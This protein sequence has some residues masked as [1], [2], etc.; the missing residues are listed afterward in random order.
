[1]TH[2]TPVSSCKRPSP[3]D[4]PS[5]HDLSTR[6]SGPLKRQ[7]TQSHKTASLPGLR[8][9]VPSQH[10]P[11]TPPLDAHGPSDM[12]LK[13]IIPQQHTNREQQRRL[14]RR[15]ADAERWKPKLQRP[16]PKPGEITTA[17]PLKLMRHYPDANMCTLPNFVRPRIDKSARLSRLLQRFPLTGS[18]RAGEASSS[19]SSSYSPSPTNEAIPL[20]ARRDAFT[21]TQRAHACLQANKQMTASG[22]AQRLAWRSFALSETGRVDRGREAMMVSGLATEDLCSEAVGVGNGLPEWK[23]HCTGLFARGRHAAG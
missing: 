1:M 8:L 15:R 4:G 3:D 2:L 17:Y 12:A 10:A 7:R 6:D 11:M 14:N 18:P 9:S 13:I 5:P 21:E 16:Y 20:S 22:D 19:E 23:K